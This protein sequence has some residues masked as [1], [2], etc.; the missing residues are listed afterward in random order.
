MALTPMDIH[1]KDFPKKVLGGYDPTAV[2]EFLDQV[3]REMEALTKENIHLREQIDGLNAKLEQ[4]RSLEESINKTLVVAQ[5]TAEDIRANARKQSDLI[6]QE[7]RLQA[8]R[9]IEAG[10]SKARKI[11]DENADLMRAA[12]TLRTQVKAL[13]LSQ[14]DAIDQVRDPFTPAAASLM[15]EARRPLLESGEEPEKL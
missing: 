11:T 4:Y 6:I 15:S 8:E 9:I 12:Y 14:L 13:L 1:N 3:I 5:E 7:A 10:Q 2:D